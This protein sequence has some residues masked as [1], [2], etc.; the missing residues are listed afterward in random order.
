[1][2]RFA[3]LILAVLI[4]LFAAVPVCAAENESIQPRYTYIASFTA[5][6][7]VHSNTG[8][9]TCTGFVKVNPGYKAKVVCRLQKQVDSAWET[10]KTWEGT[11][12]GYANV[13]EKWA[14]YSYYNYRVYVTAYVY[15]SDG[16]IVETAANVDYADYV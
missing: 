13:S 10:V 4:L 14:V 2:K 9:S 12:D 7:L 3:N 1:M 11:G 6:M 5:S 16:N 15:D 8:I